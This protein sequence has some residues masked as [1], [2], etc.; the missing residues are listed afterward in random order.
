MGNTLIFHTIY[1]FRKGKTK[2][3][4]IIERDK[5]NSYVDLFISMGDVN[6][7]VDLDVASE[8]VCRV[9]AQS[10]TQDVN[11][12]RYKKLMQMTGKVDQVI[13]M[14]TIINLNQVKPK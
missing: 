6:S 9:Y 4:T 1:C 5:T 7:V 11:E 8:F 14:R 10:S 2:P 12:A 13:K 3:L